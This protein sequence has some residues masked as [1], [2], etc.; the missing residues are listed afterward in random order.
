MKPR[1]LDQ[2]ARAID[3]ALTFAATLPAGAPERAMMARYIC[4]LASGFL[5]DIV[6]AR[7]SE[8]S[9]QS[10]PRKEID[11]YVEQS[12][13][14]FQNPKLEH[15]L[16]LAGRFNTS[17]RSH[18][19]QLDESVK[20]AINSIVANRHLIAHGRQSGVSLERILQWV[21]RAKEFRKRFDKICR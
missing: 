1:E 2:Q 16:E 11:S 17:W 9:R 3:E 7:L 21:D 5:E 14:R 18:L 20:D 10:K 6:R 12:V 4:V 15:I 19:D 8:F 13:D